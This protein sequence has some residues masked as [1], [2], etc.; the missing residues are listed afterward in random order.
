MRKFKTLS[1]LCMLTAATGAI[2]VDA[3][4]AQTKMAK[5]PAMSEPLT[6]NEL[7]KLYGNRSWIWKDG[8]GYFSVKRREFKAW[9]GEGAGSYGIGHWFVTGPGKLCF[10]AMWYAKAGNAD[11]LT[12][13]SHRR[14]G[15][16]ILQKREPDGD[17]YAFKTS[18][19]AAGDEYRKIQP[20]DYATS[21][22]VRLRAKLSPAAK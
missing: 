1:L 11:A 4:A 14:K 16:T 12:C 3:H 17:W 18:P 2:T 19:A 21:R 8:A 15:R 20:G 9:T 13:F 22:L 6:S 7:V 5:L 10:K